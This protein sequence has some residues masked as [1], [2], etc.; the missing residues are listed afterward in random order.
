MRPFKQLFNEAIDW[1]SRELEKDDFDKP[2][3][4]NSRYSL[5]PRLR[6]LVDKPDD[7]ELSERNLLLSITNRYRLYLDKEFRR[8]RDK[9]WVSRD[10]IALR[11]TIF[12]DLRKQWN[13]EWTDYEDI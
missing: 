9:K 13:I 2:F 10:G 8:L 7:L 4:N 1:F 5:L 3:V 11:E 6:K 12:E